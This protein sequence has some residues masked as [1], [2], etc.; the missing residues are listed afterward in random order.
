MSVPSPSPIRS[1][2]AP[3]DGPI[4]KA[5]RTLHLTVEEFREKLPELYSRGFPRPDQTTGMFDLEA[6]DRWQNARHPHLFGDASAQSTAE[7]RKVAEERL[8]RL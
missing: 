8:A 3:R 7:A 2:I 4:A 5:A 1:R 6:I